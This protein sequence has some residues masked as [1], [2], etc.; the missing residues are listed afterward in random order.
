MR[1]AQSGL[2]KSHQGALSHEGE[3]LFPSVFL[4]AFEG[5]KSERSSLSTE[6]L[7]ILSKIYSVRVT[8]SLLL[9]AGGENALFAQCL[10]FICDFYEALNSLKGINETRKRVRKSLA[11]S[12]RVEVRYPRVHYYTE[13]LTGWHIQLAVRR[14]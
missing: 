6:L 7:Y 11:H 4:T 5:C 12:P 2:R 10:G 9:E 1:S 3:D 13:N 8:Q 14:C